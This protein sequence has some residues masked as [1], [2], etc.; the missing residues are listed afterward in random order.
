M[1]LIQCWRIPA[2]ALRLCI[3]DNIQAVSSI[4]DVR[5]RD[6]AKTLLRDA[7]AG[8]GAV[9][10][11]VGRQNNQGQNHQ[12]FERNGSS[13]VRNGESRGLQPSKMEGDDEYEVKKHRLPSADLHGMTRQAR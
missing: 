11:G 10:G 5:S 4:N 9:G 13:S 1:A 8:A 3:V 12:E 2:I 7:K 6:G